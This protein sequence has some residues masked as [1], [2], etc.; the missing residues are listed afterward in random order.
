MS[1]TI[2]QN[3][4]FQVTFTETNLRYLLGE[5]H[6]DEAAIARC[7]VQLREA[8]QLVTSIKDGL[9]I[10]TQGNVNMAVDSECLIHF[11]NT[12][13]GRVRHGLTDSAKPLCLTGSYHLRLTSNP[14]LVTCTRC[15]AKLP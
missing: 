4:E 9:K 13:E 6:P 10:Y 12:D 1:P 5:E 14:R 3:A 7:E 8:E 11:D 2:L 15:R